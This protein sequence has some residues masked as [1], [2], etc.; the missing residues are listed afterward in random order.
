MGGGGQKRKDRT[1]VSLAAGEPIKKDAIVTSILFLMLA[2]GAFIESM[3]L[4]FGA[5]LLVLLCG[6]SSG[7][8]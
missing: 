5:G 2:L 4:P 1:T 3:K 6:D 8:P 7:K